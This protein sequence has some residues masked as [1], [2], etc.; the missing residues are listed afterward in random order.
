MNATQQDTSTREVEADDIPITYS[1]DTEEE[2][3]EEGPRRARLIGFKADVPKLDWKLQA[4]RE[5]NPDKEVD[6]HQYKWTFWLIDEEREIEDWTA[7]T[8]HPKS[9]G[10]KY[11][12]Y[13]QGK[14][15]LEGDE[16][17][18]STGALLNRELMLF[19]TKGK[20]R[21]YANAGRS[22]PVPQ[23]KGPKPQVQV[24]SLSQDLAD[25][26]EDADF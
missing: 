13:L 2:M 1:A 15:R 9:N 23:R 26:Y 22:F 25:P 11:A 17:I 16:R 4:D 12:A 14:M 24:Q 19:V 8:F 20:S 18:R 21:N 10:G 6:T 7:R 5:R 3:L